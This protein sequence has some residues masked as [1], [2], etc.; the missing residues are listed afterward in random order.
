[1][2]RLTKEQIDAYA[3]HKE[4]LEHLRSAAADAVVNYNYELECLDSPAPALEELNEAIIEFNTWVE[5]VREQMENYFD[6]RSEH[7]LAGEKGKPYQ[8]WIDSLYY[9]VDEVATEPEE[10]TQ[11]DEPEV[12]I[13]KVAESP[14]EV[15]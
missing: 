15:E 6:E 2:K 7:E 8:A 3:H 11:M 9:E 12:E 4:N 1:M 5:G 14:E 10:P 13:T